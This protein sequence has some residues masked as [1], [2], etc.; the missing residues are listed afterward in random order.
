MPS[1]NRVQN[2]AVESGDILT[3]STVRSLRDN[4]MAILGAGGDGGALNYS[5]VTRTFTM[6]NAYN[7]G[8]AFHRAGFAERIESVSGYPLWARITSISGSFHDE[9]IAGTDNYSTQGVTIT[10]YNSSVRVSAGMAYFKEDVDSSTRRWRP[11]P[12][13]ITITMQ[14]GYLH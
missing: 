13:S 3:E 9:G 2:N 6:T 12:R 11:L 4:P 7:A 5:V 1:Y 8:G 14:I 10:L